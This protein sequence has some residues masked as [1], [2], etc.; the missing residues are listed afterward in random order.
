MKVIGLTGGVGSGK[1][2]AAHLLQEMTGAH[3]LI[4]DELGHVAM[5][6]GS[7]GYKEIIREFGEDILAEDGTI[8]RGKLASLVFAGEER[9][10][11]LNAIVHP[12]V[13]AYL[14]DYIAKRR[15]EEGLIILESAIMFE[16][17]CDIL[18]DEIWYVCVP[19]NLRRERLKESRGYS[20]EKSQS[21][22]DRQLSE[23]VFRQRCQIIIE[24]TGTVEKL[25][26][27]L[28]EACRKSVPGIALSAEGTQ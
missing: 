21:I 1:S 8:D 25:K 13:K 23:E 26:E 3:L 24:N 7:G 27:V 22:M 16:S 6:K 18:C 10:A 28:R 4:A 2:L 20:R 14:Q 17:G 19:E 5:E 11:V 15:S 9:L 12:R